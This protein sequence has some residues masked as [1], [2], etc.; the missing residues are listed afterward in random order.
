MF[1]M[2]IGVGRGEGVF[3]NE[4]MQ[5]NG[6]INRSILQM[7]KLRLGVICLTAGYLLCNSEGSS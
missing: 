2:D 4:E 7:E 3:G 6:G 1:W 5:G